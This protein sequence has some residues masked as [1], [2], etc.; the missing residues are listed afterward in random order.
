MTQ[1][2]EINRPFVSKINWTVFIQSMTNVAVY[3]LAD[4]GVIPQEAVVDVLVAANIVS[5]GLIA[6]FRTWFTKP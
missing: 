6:V 2:I 1:K 3:F 4:Q 5:G